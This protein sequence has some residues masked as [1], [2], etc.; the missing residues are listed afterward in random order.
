MRKKHSTK[1]SDADS[2]SSG[3]DITDR[4][5]E[6]LKVIEGLL[7]QIKREWKWNLQ[8]HQ[9]EPALV[10]ANI[11]TQHEPQAPLTFYSAHSILQIK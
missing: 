7:A 3:D 8:A 4:I 2:R 10:F 1:D 11:D 5:I 6:H 9:T